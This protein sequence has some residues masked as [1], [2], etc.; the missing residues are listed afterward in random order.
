VKN[1]YFGDVNDFKKYGLLKQLS[2]GCASEIAVCWTLT[3]DDSRSDGSRIRYLEEPAKWRTLDPPLFDFV[4]CQ[5]IERGVRSV[6]ALAESRALPNCRFFPELLPDHLA[7]REAYFE[8]F[9]RFAQGADLVF[10]DP[11]NGLGITA[12]QRGGRNSSKYVYPCEVERAWDTGKSVLFYQH[13]PRRPRDSFLRNLTG[14]F[15]HLRGLRLVYFFI[16]S[17]VVF[18][19][20]PSAVHEHWLTSAAKEFE[21]HWAGVVRVE[22]HE[23]LRPVMVNSRQRVDVGPRILKRPAGG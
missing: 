18:V 2:N 7:E 11:D 4:R 12:I 19:L 20:L 14:V 9:F 22:R 16:T 6:E 1:Q 15:S 3:E 23:L 8:R 17:H 13:F 21:R 10:F 5:V